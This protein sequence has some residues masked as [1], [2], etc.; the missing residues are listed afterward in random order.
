MLSAPRC[1]C[2]V[3]DAQYLPF[4]SSEEEL[5]QEDELS[6]RTIKM[7]PNSSRKAKASRLTRNCHIHLATMFDQAVYAVEELYEVRNIPGA[8]PNIQRHVSRTVDREILLVTDGSCTSANSLQGQRKAS[9]CK[10]SAGATFIYRQSSSKADVQSATVFPFR[11]TDQLG[12]LDESAVGD[13]QR[14]LSNA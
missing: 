10:P 9:G 6:P 2:D 14:R 4:G 5:I 11:M 12:P 1:S 7:V 13:W 8:I 3:F